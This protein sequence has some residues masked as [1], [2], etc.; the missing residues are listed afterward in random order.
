MTLQKLTY[1]FFFILKTMTPF[2]YLQIDFGSLFLK[3]KFE[4][5]L[6]RVLSQS[7]TLVQQHHVR[8]VDV[9]HLVGVYRHQNT[10]DVR[11]K[12]HME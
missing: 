8:P 10:T 7:T 3:F 5:D 9:V 2:C 4:H 1:C 6:R 11:L 12:E